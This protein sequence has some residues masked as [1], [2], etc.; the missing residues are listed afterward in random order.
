MVVSTKKKER[1]PPLPEEKKQSVRDRRSQ[2]DKSVPTKLDK[3]LGLFEMSALADLNDEEADMLL[4]DYFPDDF[5]Q[6]IVDEGNDE[7]EEEEAEDEYLPNRAAKKGQGKKRK[8]MEK[9]EKQRTTSAPNQ[10]RPVGGLDPS[11][12]LELCDWIQQQKEQLSSQKL[13]LHA[14][15]IARR[16]TP[17]RPT[18]SLCWL[19][20]FII[21]HPEI[22]DHVR[23]RSSSTQKAL[24]DAEEKEIATV[25]RIVIISG[26]EY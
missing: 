24:S 26:K 4:R 25:R 2:K 17:D 3:N 14:T 23:T 10:P 8:K 15:E 18:F 19:K 7:L 6:K 16:T 1:Y 11:E 9:S 13:L 21:R 5:Q 22:V 20:H 12:E